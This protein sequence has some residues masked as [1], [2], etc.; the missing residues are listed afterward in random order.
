MS[1]EFVF[2]YF[3][4]IAV[5][6]SEISGYDAGEVLLVEGIFVGLG[7]SG[8]I[9]GDEILIKDFNSDAIIVLKDFLG[10]GLKIP[11]VKGDRIILYVT[12]ATNTNPAFFDCG[13]KYTL[14]KMK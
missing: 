10:D 9:G 2:T 8:N 7:L 5:H 14:R 13:K 4:D 12:V 3:V 11:L 6:V 1:E